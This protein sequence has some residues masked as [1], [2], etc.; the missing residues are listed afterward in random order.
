MRQLSKVLIRDD[1]NKPCSFA[2][3]LSIQPRPNAQSNVKP[4]M[5]V[6]L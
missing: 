3:S 6:N 1:E 5:M 4:N 2:I